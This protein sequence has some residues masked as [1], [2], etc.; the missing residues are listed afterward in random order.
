MERFKTL[1]LLGRPAAGKSEVI[2]FLKKTPPPE[3]LARFHVGE[4][5]EFD[6]FPY[7]WERFEDDMLLEKVGLERVWTTS[8]LYFKDERLWDFFIEK[9]NLAYGKALRDEPDFHEKKTAVVEFSRGGKRGWRHAFHEVV[10]PDLLEGSAVLYIH[11]TYEESV[12]KNRRRFNPEKPDSILEHGLPD[13]KMERLYKVSDWEEFT[14]GDPE[15]LTIQGIRVPYVVLNNMPEVTDDPAK[16][17]PA[18]ERELG[19]LWE[20]RSRVL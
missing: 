12:R 3:R 20:I 15:V 13:E 10:S 9:L 6:D 19:R 18:L 8:D 16:L 7:I 2:D 5:R 4:F 14:A 17:G 11:V 1:F